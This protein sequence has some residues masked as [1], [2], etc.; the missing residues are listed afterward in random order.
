MAD[1]GRH[2]CR[3]RG[4]D[5]ADNPAGSRVDQ[6]LKV[7]DQKSVAL[8]LSSYRLNNVVVPELLVCFDRRS[9]PVRGPPPRS[10]SL[11]DFSFIAFRDRPAGIP[12]DCFI[13]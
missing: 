9:M 3:H 6:F 1:A 2:H 7:S 10:L 12:L 8:L 13:Y 5:S 11:S 4:Y